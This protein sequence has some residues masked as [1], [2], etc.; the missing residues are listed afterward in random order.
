MLI[1]QKSLAEE[2]GHI[3]AERKK[4]LTALLLLLTLP[5]FIRW[6]SVNDLS[7]GRNVKEVF[8]CTGWLTNR[9][10]FA[11]ATGLKAKKTLNCIIFLLEAR[12]GGAGA[13]LTPDLWLFAFFF[14]KNNETKSTEIINRTTA[15]TP[16]LIQL[17]VQN[18]P[19]AIRKRRI[20][21][22]ARFK[23]EIFTSTLTSEHLSTKEMRIIGLIKQPST[24][25]TRR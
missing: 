2:L 15:K 23:A 19:Y 6:V 11:L 25:I 4:L 18:A 7:V 8:A 17:I 20:A 22:P 24:T 16:A 5:A 1:L 10:T 21:L 13:F 3:R 14:T 12:A 9:R